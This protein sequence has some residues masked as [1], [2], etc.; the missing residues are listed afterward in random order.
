MAGK[1]RP[2]PK[3]SGKNVTT[4]GIALRSDQI[5][6]LQKKAVQRLPVVGHVSMSLVVRSLI[7]EAMSK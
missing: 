1:G 4:M 7:D 6:W 3:P 2:G 5:E